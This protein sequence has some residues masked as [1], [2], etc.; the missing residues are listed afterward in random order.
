MSAKP[1]Q[2]NVSK[3]KDNNDHCRG[4]EREALNECIQEIWKSESV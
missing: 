2:N 1:K 3:E 4:D